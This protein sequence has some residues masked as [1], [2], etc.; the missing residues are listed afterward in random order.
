MGEGGTVLRGKQEGK[1]VLS[2][3]LGQALWGLDLQEDFWLRF[4]SHRSF[5]KGFKRGSF[6]E[7]FRWMA[8]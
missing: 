5:W 6:S 8:F 3:W 1:A 4:G 7:S 2:G